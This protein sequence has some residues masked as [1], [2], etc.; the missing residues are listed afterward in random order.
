MERVLSDE[1]K[2]R[3]A[4]EIYQR[5]R[6][7]NVTVPSRDLNRNTQKKDT[8]RFKKMLI[9]IGVSILIYFTIYIIQNSNLFFSSEFIKKVEMILA[10]DINFS[11]KITQLN[12]YIKNNNFLKRLISC[13]CA[14]RRR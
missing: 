3:K 2:F 10:Y 5:R 6:N 8:K 4:E 12:D 11:E 1:E 14:G 7:V 9:Q 13:G